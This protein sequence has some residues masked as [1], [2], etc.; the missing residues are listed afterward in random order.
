[1]NL[2]IERNLE[3]DRSHTVP[4]V[5]VQGALS[6]VYCCL[7]IAQY[8]LIRGLLDHNLGEKI[9]NFKKELLTHMQDPKI[10]V[11][12]VEECLCYRQLFPNEIQKESQVPS[13][14]N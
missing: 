13:W 12:H 9:E 11:G 2:Q 1:L 10:Q 4:D 8:K 3:G 6:S 5:R 7:D 14:Q